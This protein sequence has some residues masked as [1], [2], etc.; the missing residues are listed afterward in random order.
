MDAKYVL[1]TGTVPVSEKAKQRILEGLWLSYYNDVLYAQ[2]IISENDRN[3]MRAK[4]KMR[5]NVP[6]QG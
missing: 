3:R 1:N 6:K 4:I 5:M 2:G